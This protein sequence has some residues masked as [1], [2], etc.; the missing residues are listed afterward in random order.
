[1]SAYLELRRLGRLD[2][3]GAAVLYAVCAAVA[4]HSG[5]PPVGGG[6]W[7]EDTV[8]E[9]AHDFLADEATHG[10][11][12]PSLFV[13]AHDDESLRAMLL[14]QI[15]NFHISRLRGED[16]VA[17][18]QRLVRVAADSDD[19]GVIDTPAGKAVTLGEAAV[20]DPYA[21]PTSVL[22]SAARGVDVRIVRWRSAKRRDPGADDESVRQVL[23]AMIEAVDAPVLLGDATRTLTD[24]FGLYAAPIRIDLQ[25]EPAADDDPAADGL[26]SVAVDEAWAQL[27][28]AERQLLASFDSIRQMAAE[29]GRAKSSVALQVRR[30]VGVLTRLVGDDENSEAVVE[31]LYARAVAW[32]QNV[33]T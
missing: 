21:G 31:Q 12:I 5:L 13:R 1:M 25:D 16:A 15:R 18:H 6:S 23:R 28:T 14:V 8:R 17:L 30:L 10:R 26:V 22:D 32:A 9:L 7:Q 29:L 24:V 4:H 33:D 11:R 3:E 19:L 27:S 20:T 2:A